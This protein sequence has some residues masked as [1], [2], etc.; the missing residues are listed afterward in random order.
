MDDQVE[1]KISA[2]SWWPKVAAVT[3]ISHQILC[4]MPAPTHSHIS[5]LL[6]T[7]SLYVCVCSELSV[8]GFSLCRFKE[9]QVED[10]FKNWTCTEFHS[11]FSKRDIIASFKLHLFIYWVHVG[12]CIHAQI[13]RS[14]NILQELV[15]SYC[16]RP[17]DWTQVTRFDHKHLHP[18]GDHVGPNYC[19][20]FMLC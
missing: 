11:L 17:K 6:G 15:L 8:S 9:L 13:W 1:G 16:T 2:C 3:K 14:D 5:Q 4:T 20:V 19:I 7:K 18:L 10:I 12:E